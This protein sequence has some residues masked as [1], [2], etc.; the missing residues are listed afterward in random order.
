MQR[1]SSRSSLRSIMA[2]SNTSTG[3]ITG[4][5][6]SMESIQRHSTLIAKRI[7]IEMSSSALLISVGSGI[8]VYPMMAA[9]VASLD[10]ALVS[11]HWPREPGNPA[12]SLWSLASVR[13]DQQKKKGK[14]NGIKCMWREFISR[15]HLQEGGRRIELAVGSPSVDWNTR[16][17]IHTACAASPRRIIRPFQR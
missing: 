16:P 8:L 5:I 4:S 6:T 7:R 9:R 13:K 17:N 14:K 12:P 11:L 1:C 3:C 15:T 2:T 10:G